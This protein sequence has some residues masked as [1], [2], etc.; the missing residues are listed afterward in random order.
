MCSSFLSFLFLCYLIVR[1]FVLI[2]WYQNFKIKDIWKK[3]ILQ[4]TQDKDKRSFSLM[5]SLLL[6]HQDVSDDM[7]FDPR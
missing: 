2:N 3:E 5:W 6:S 4:S 1:L 7:E